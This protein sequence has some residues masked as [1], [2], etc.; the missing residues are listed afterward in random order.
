ML[1][2]LALR[3]EEFE[4][5]DHPNRDMWTEQ[6]REFSN[7][8][9]QLVEGRCIRLLLS[10]S[11]TNSKPPDHA[12]YKKLANWN[13]IICTGSTCYWCWEMPGKV[14]FY[15]HVLNSQDF[16]DW[17]RLY[18]HYTGDPFLPTRESIRYSMKN[19]TELEQ[20]VH[21]HQTY[22]RSKRLAERLWWT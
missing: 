21:R 10:V 2:L 12:W 19:G 4:Q 7:I 1:V 14:L 11:W 9:H 6:T 22:C 5:G 17:L 15:D 8:R 18:S 3:L 16:L 20:V 13:E